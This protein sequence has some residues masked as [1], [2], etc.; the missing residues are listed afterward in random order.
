[1]WESAHNVHLKIIWNVQEIMLKY[2]KME[3]PC[4]K[5]KIRSPNTFCKTHSLLLCD[6][7]YF[8]EHT[9]CTGMLLEEYNQT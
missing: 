6:E 2:Q 5:C 9:N 4:I 1:M 8:E 7:C 3:K